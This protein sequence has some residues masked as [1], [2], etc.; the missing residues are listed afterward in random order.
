MVKSGKILV[1]NP[2]GRSHLGELG[3]HGSII[4]KWMLRTSDVRMCTG[5]VWLRTE[6]SGRLF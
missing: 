6:S 3:V 5:S 1:E 2:K 4:I